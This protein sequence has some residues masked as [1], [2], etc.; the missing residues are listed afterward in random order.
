MPNR[1]IELALKQGRLQERIATQRAALAA[2][3]QPI[4]GALETADVAI[5]TGR[6]GLNY[7]KRHP[8]QVGAAFAVLAILRPKRVWQ[9]GRRA[10]IAWSL[11][12][13]VRSQLN[14]A[15]LIPRRRTA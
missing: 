7:I 13:K 9:W 15:G 11:W 1:Q 3:M 6:S 10:F 2:Q 5:G 14:Q 8:G 4:A 12:R